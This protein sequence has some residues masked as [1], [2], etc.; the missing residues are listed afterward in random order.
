M[1]QLLAMLPPASNDKTLMKE[2]AYYER[3]V[4]DPSLHTP[5]TSGA[6]S[7]AAAAVGAVVG[8]ALYKVAI[9]C[10]VRWRKLSKSLILPEHAV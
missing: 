7:V 3:A 6:E 5:W 2:H 10:Y 1:I 8:F 9:A 4:I